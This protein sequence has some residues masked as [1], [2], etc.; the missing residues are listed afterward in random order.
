MG[1]EEVERRRRNMG[2]SERVSERD[3]QRDRGT[4]MQESKTSVTRRRTCSLL[5]LF[6]LL[7]FF[8]PSA[9]VIC[10]LF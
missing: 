3:M 5:I 1:E 2:E 10:S 6:P 8:R 4:Y 9:S 7:F